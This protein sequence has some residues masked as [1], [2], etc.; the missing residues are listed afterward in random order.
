MKVIR[1]HRLS[2]VMILSTIPSIAMAEPWFELDAYAT[3]QYSDNAKKTAKPHVSERQDIIGLSLTGDHFANY[4]SVATDYQFSHYRFS[5]GLQE[6]RNMLDGELFLTVADPRRYYGVYLS[7]TRRGLLQSAEQTPLLQNYDQRQII[8][9]SPFMNY[10]LSRVDTLQMRLTTSRV[11]FENQK[12]KDSSQQGGSIA[13]RHRLNKLSAVSLGGTITDIEFK[14]QPSR[15]YQYALVYLNYEL[16][17]RQLNYTLEIGYN[18]TQSDD[19]GDHDS[20]SFQLTVNYQAEPWQVSLFAHRAITDTSNGDG[21]RENIFDLPSADGSN[22]DVDQIDRQS[23][24]F[25]LGYSGLCRRCQINVSAEVRNDDYLTLNDD[26]HEL[27][28]STGFRYELTPRSYLDLHYQT[29]RSTYEDRP[30][31]DHF[32]TEQVRMSWFNQLNRNVSARLFIQQEQR[33]AYLGREGYR[34]KLVGL[35]LSYAY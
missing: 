8:N 2:T 20:P 5:E 4:Y 32:K 1:A 28:Y 21:N 18:Q 6:D 27:S 16:A 34:E 19:R 14:H 35:T 13:W 29:R 31:D 26:N 15:D 12:I 33:S 30:E 3:T 17:L 7:H 22:A 9:I 23:I 25:E 10:P 24:I 11:D